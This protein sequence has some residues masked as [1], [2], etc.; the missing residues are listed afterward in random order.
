MRTDYKGYDAKRKVVKNGSYAY[1]KSSE[2]AKLFIFL[3]DASSEAEWSLEQYKEKNEFLFFISTNHQS[4]AVSHYEGNDSRWK[5]LIFNIHSHPGVGFEGTKGASGYGSALAE[6][7]YLYMQN[8][9]NKW[10][11]NNSNNLGY[12][13]YHYVYHRKSKELFQYTRF[14][15]SIPLGVV[16]NYDINKN[17]AKSKPSNYGY[18]R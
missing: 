5:N 6:G 7:D 15:S 12:F 17:F 14:V 1:S 9:Y 4:D 8:L 11:Y 3:S 18:K 13:P 2:S 16:K 10:R